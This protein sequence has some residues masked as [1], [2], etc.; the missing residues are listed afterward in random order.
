M[1]NGHSSSIHS[2][3]QLFATPAGVDR[4]DSKNKNAM[5][6]YDYIVVGGG[7]AGC[8]LASRLSE[9]RGVTVLLI[10]AGKSHE[11]DFITSIPFAFT[12]TFKTRVDWCFMS[13]PQSALHDRK[14]DLM[15]GKILGGTTAINA[16]IYH[17]CAPQDFNQWASL[18]YTGWGYSDMQTYFRKAEK[19]T[20]HP[21]YPGINAEERGKDGLWSTG[22]S[23]EALAPI[24]NAAFQACKTLGIPETHDANTPRGTSGVTDF[25]AMIDENGRR[26]TTAT[27]YLTK[28]VLARP[29][30]TIGTNTQVNKILFEQKD[31]EEPR[32]IGIEVSTGPSAPRYHAWAKHEVILSA[33]AFGSPKLLLLSGIG[34]ASELQ[35]LDI[36]IVK[37]VPAVGKYLSDHVGSGGLN[38]RAKTGTWDYLRKPFPGIHALFNWYFFGTGPLSTLCVPSAAFVRS[39]DPKLPFDSKSSGELAIKDLTSGPGVPDIELLWAPATTVGCGINDPPSGSVGITMLAINLRPESTGS[40]T[41]KSNNPWEDPVVDPNYLVSESDLNVVLRA[42]RLAQRV[43]RT[44][45]LASMLDLRPQEAGRHQDNI[46][47]VGDVDPDQVTD[48]ELK[49]FIRDNALPEYHPISSARMGL[50]PATSVVD[51]ELRVHG[52]KGLRVVDG[53]VFPTQVTGHPCAVIVAIAEKAA[54]LIKGNHST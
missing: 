15:R 50:D 44:G 51:V 33:G 40:V 43:A 18:G 11:G 23:R 2:D 10:E 6:E 41:L 25:I 32:A 46:Y 29:N 13:T 16:S 45:P 26:V 30:L 35:A 24:C 21:S 52:I 19:Y 9:D 8:V 7:A 38:F 4:G 17:H 12:Q 14:I 48:E 1:G 22:H 36:P 42:V 47:W 54:D 53:S 31:G 5:R 49:D 37:D 27:S 28:D 39:D 3:P 20:P 34:P